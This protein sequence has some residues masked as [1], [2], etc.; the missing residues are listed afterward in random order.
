MNREDL[1][2]Y[3][4]ENFDTI[5]DY[6]W[7]NF[8]NFAVLRHLKNRKWY[9]LIMNISKAKL[10]LKSFKCVD[11][12]NVKV[13]PERSYFLQQKSDIYPA[14]HMNREHW[15]SILLNGKVPNDEIYLLLQQSFELTK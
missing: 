15:V 3:A 7:K 6:P 14:Y 12:L 11:V 5:P 1:F 9:G 13:N 2:V 8:P 10:G 4:Q